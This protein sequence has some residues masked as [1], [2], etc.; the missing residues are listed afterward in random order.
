MRAR[1]DG[2]FVSEQQKKNH[3][4]LLGSVNGLTYGSE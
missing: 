1:A 4:N 2:G 3:R